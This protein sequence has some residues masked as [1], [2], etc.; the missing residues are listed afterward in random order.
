MVVL[1]SPRVVTVSELAVAAV[2][3]VA[4]E[5]LVLRTREEMAELAYRIP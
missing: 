5:W 1:A 4:L 2:A 3:L